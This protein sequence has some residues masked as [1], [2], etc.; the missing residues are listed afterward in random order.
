MKTKMEIR[1]EF[2][3]ESGI[4]VLLCAQEGIILVNYYFHRTR[5]TQIIMF[6]KGRR[7]IEGEKIITYC[8]GIKIKSKHQDWL[9]KDYGV[10][11]DDGFNIEWVSDKYKRAG[12]I[13]EKMGHIWGGHFKTLY[14]PYHFQIRRIYE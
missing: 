13:W 12:E 9:A 10:L 6:A 3:R 7:G 5:Q 2:D 4:L 1:A 14:D 11:S 8:D